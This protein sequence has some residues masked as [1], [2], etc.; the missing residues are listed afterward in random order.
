M[1]SFSPRRRTRA[2]VA[3]LAAGCVASGLA[4]MPGSS[5]ASAA[6]AP[7]ARAH[8]FVDAFSSASRG[9]GA[10]FR[11]WWPSTVDPD[12]AVRQLRQ[13]RDA[14]YRGV[15][16]AF[17]MDGTNYVV[18]ADEHEYGDANW[19]AAVQAVL[20]EANRL[21]LQVDLTLGGRWPAGVP[22]LDVSS[23]AASQE[24]ITGDATVEAG[25]TF[26]AE[27]PAPPQLTYADRTMENGVI[28]TTTKVSQP[29]LVT[30]SAAA[31][32]AACASANPQLDLDTVLDLRDSITDGRLEWTAPDPGTWVVTAYWQRGTA[33]R[34]DAPF[35]TST[36]PLSDPETRVVNHFSAAGSD[37]ITGFMGSLLNTRTRRLL[38]ANGGSI[39]EDSLE[40]R[41]SQLWTPEFFDR[42]R[43]VNGYSVAAYLPVLARSTAPGPFQPSPA[44]YTFGAGQAEA[45]ERIDVDIEQ[46]L[47]VL[48]RDNHAKPI[49]AWANSLG[50]R[51]RAQAYGEPIDL[52][53]AAGYLDISECE[54]LGCSEAQFRTASAGVALAG[55]SL[56]SS[57]MLPGGFGNLYGLS[58]AQVAAL[59]NKEYSYGANQM[60]FHGLPYPTVPASADGTIVDDASF[61]PG[62]HGFSAL[63][64]EAFGPRQPTW[65]MERDISGYYAR[66]QRVLRAGAL[67]LDVAVLN[68]TLNGGTPT[69]DG[70]PLLDAGM[71]YGYV[72]PGSLRDQRVAGGRLA[73]EGPAFQGMVVGDEP[74][75]VSTARR[76]RRMV[77]DGLTVVVIVGP[78]RARGYAASAA[79]AEDQDAIVE[80]LF[81]EIVASPNGHR[82]TGPADAAEVLETEGVRA[83]AAVGNGTVKAVHRRTGDLDL[84]ALV[85]RGAEDVTTTVT[86]LGRSGNVPYALDPWTGKVTPE[87][88]FTT[89]GN[90][91]T[92]DVTI[93]AGST[94]LVALAGR[95]FTGSTVPTGRVVSTDAEDAAWSRRLTLRADDAG[96]FTSRLSNG[97][98]VR[99]TVTGVP[100]STRLGDW[101]LRLDEWLPGGAGDAS[102]VTRHEIHDLPDVALA[103]W[104]EIEG[105]ENAVGVGTYTTHVD[106]G[107]RLAKAGAVLDLGKVGGPTACTSTAGW[108]PFPTSSGRWSTSEDGSRRAGTSSR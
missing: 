30:A 7:V 60:V 92:L 97:R 18:D 4:L 16:I 85:N 34:N 76:I 56:L 14:G 35:G 83:E 107:R 26:D 53:E 101:D 82:A 36:S 17:V 44:V 59:A 103:S 80:Q 66:T 5:P 99:T 2:W 32:V 23:N 69:L 65:T 96:T 71:S 24:L 40:L 87:G 27:A 10:M 74:V 58:P 72:T 48:Y 70:A 49:K 22:G 13:V 94:E 63:I 50:L 108:S 98:A 52:G 91:T 9:T 100:A 12:V 88:V 51:Y 54:S 86:L 21:G 104:T 67:K 62:F 78:Q 45:V 42:F 75:D 90:R 55:T 33:Q 20:T 106:A 64:G 57:E 1:T 77:A 38:R 37:A 43:Q 95:R 8:P 3:T 61:W 89:S 73:P 28:T 81:D 6:A 19:R 84:Y 105:I 29:T 46:T 93:E 15:E 68:Q 41:A 31:C 47:N 79:A 102:S 39:F 11:W 25:Q